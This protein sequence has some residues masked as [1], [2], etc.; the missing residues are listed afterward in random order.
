MD[1]NKVTSG[2]DNNS[3][4]LNTEK[5]KR[6]KTS[7]KL[8]NLDEKIEVSIAN[9]TPLEDPKPLNFVV[10]YAEAALIAGSIIDSEVY[11]EVCEIVNSDDFSSSTYKEIWK[12][13]VACETQG[14]PI[15]RL[16]IADELKKAG[17]LGKVG[18]ILKLD[19]IVKEADGL[20]NATAY[21]ELVS[22]KALGRRVAQ[23]SRTIYAN[24]IK[25][26][27]TG[28]DSLEFAEKEIFSVHKLRGKSDLVG[29][30][31][32]VPET[33]KD[34]ATARESRI[35]G[36]STGFRELDKLTGGV[37]GGQLIVIA[38]RPGMGKSALAL[39]LARN[40]AE[41]SGKTVAFLSYEM[42]RKELTIRLFA[43][44]LDVE[45]HLLRQGQFP[46]EM[47]ADL[48]ASA[49]RLESCSLLI[50]DRPPDTVAGVRASMRRLARK[51]PVSA[52]VIDYL[53]L[54][55]ASKGENRTQ[56]V[57]EISRGLKQLARELDTPV[58]ALSQLNRQLE[59]RAEKR[60]QLS[61]LRDSGSIEQDADTVWFLY[62]DWVYNPSSDKGACEL[63]IAKQRQGP[64]PVTVHLEFKSSSTKFVDRPREYQAPNRGFIGNS[65]FF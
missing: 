37:Q 2:P 4:A 36:E 28:A 17:V 30:N 40:V 41:S 5:V 56:E 14:R 11:W 60:P 42:S 45:L 18:G 9:T 32:A 38:A 13:I 23:V 65:K 3:E 62:R 26:S 54:M 43:S 31:V 10:E 49:R 53:Q 63:V 47:E 6:R 44:V 57:S 29:M 55:Q 1:E 19:D 15:D 35:L 12:A 51:T 50:S 33:L 8:K 61:D 48:I 52:I 20:S 34:L 59:N 24:V 16:T 64:A 7:N 58:I 27:S 25:P 21:A 46:V 39:A 22:D